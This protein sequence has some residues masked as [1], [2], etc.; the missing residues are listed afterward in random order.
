MPES[1]AAREAPTAALSLR[2]RVSSMAK[3]SLVLRPRPPDTT[4]F[5]DA[6]SGRSLLATSSL[7]HSD[8][9]AGATSTPA[10]ATV[11]DPPS[12]DAFSKD[13]GRTVNTLIGSSDLTVARA[14]PA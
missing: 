6:S 1:T 9:P 3:F 4:V 13:V 7:S 2:A 8:L 14:L 11:A 5:A 10:A 12:A